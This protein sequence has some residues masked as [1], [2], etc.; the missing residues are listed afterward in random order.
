MGQIFATADIGSNTVHLLIAETDG[1]RIQRLANESEWLSLG[2]VVG[3]E[4]RIPP[5]DSDRLL[6][7]LARFAQMVTLAKAEKFYVFATEAMRIAEN[8]EAVLS[9][10]RRELKITVDL[11]TPV[12]EA[13]LSLR[14]IQLDS[15]GVSPSALLEIGGGSAQVAICDGEKVTQEVSLP[16]GTGRLIAQTSLS[17][18]CSAVQIDSLESLIESQMEKLAAFPKP[19]RVV[20][21][22]GV[23][24]GLWKALHPDND[25][26]VHAEE[27]E[28]LKWAVPRLPLERL[29]TRFNVRAKRAQT[30]LPGAMAFAR[31]L[32]ALGHDHM[33]VSEFGVRDGAILEMFDRAQKRTK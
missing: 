33:T 15:E 29:A 2:E 7:V 11:I 21:S 19:R 3:R 23:A 27:L 14:G 13:E 22:G 16:L 17:Y 4:R 30:L 32:E 6:A 28:Y 26:E 25:R 20:A 31:L 9:R 10:V 18:P 24:R 5:A 1:L 12:R 8:H